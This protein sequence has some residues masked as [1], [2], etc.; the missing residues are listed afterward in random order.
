MRPAVRY[1]ECGCCTDARTVRGVIALEDALGWG[2]APAAH[3]P[4]SKGDLY[5]LGV[6]TTSMHAR[7]R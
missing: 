3:G 1:T 6:V 5:D 2:F 7:H 4:V